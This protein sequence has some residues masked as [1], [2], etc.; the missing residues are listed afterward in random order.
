MRRDHAE[1]EVAWSPVGP[2]LDSVIE[3]G[4]A[5]EQ[6]LQWAGDVVEEARGARA[7]GCGFGAQLGDFG[8]QLEGM[9]DVRVR[10]EV[11][12]CLFGFGGNFYRGC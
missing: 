6:V 8:D 4:G 3:V 12:V 2:A 9:P 5:L 10:E 11:G 1:A 7:D